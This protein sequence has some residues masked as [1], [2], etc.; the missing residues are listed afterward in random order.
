[1]PLNDFDHRLHSL[2]VFLVWT[3]FF[4]RC[5]FLLMIFILNFYTHAHRFSMAHESNVFV[6]RALEPVVETLKVF[7][8]SIHKIDAE[9]FCQNVGMK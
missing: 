3:F 7:F 2:L 1:M 4:G 9:L 8:F 6:L 5:R